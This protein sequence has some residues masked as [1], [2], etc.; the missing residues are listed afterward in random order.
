[1]NLKIDDELKSITRQIIAE[2]KNEHEW[3]L[4]ESSDMYQSSHYCGGFDKNENAF[5][6]SYYDE[7]ENEYW[8]Q[9]T[10][11]ECCLIEANKMLEIPLHRAG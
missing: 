6:F 7:K 1:M 9:I 8:F 4:I 10:L 2:Q 3:S 5:C 11:K